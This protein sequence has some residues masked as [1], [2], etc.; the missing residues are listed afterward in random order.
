MPATNKIR[1]Q[2]PACQRPFA[3]FPSQRSRV[4]FCSRKCYHVTMSRLLQE[5]YD[6]LRPKS[7]QLPS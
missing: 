6:S 3:R 1:C 4:M 7:D 5:L 2:C